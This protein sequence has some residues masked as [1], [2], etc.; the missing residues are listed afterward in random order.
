MKRTYYSFDPQRASDQVIIAAPSEGDEILVY[1]PPIGVDFPWIESVDSL[2]AAYHLAAGII[3][4]TGQP[5]PIVTFDNLRWWMIGLHP[6][7]LAS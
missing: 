3:T 7:N 6:V 2:E 1:C 4:R 5:E